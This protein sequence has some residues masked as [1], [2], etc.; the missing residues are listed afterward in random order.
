MLYLQGGS[1]KPAGG[2]GTT[3]DREI[4]A[5]VAPAQCTLVHHISWDVPVALVTWPAAATRSPHPRGRA[6]IECTKWKK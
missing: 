3:I 4:D 6:V 5:Q 1:E 2:N